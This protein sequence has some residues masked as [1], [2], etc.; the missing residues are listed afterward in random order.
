M[1]RNAHYKANNLTSC[2]WFNASCISAIA[3]EVQ[4]RYKD[5]T[6]N[7][8]FVCLKKQHEHRL[9]TSTVPEVKL[10]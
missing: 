9:A 2:P 6:S 4:K 7:L 1:K 8:V 3:A 10:N 5:L